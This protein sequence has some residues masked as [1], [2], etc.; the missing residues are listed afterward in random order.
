MMYG[1]SYPWKDQLEIC[2]SQVN[3]IVNNNDNFLTIFRPRSIAAS[4]LI[5]MAPPI[6]GS[7]EC[8]KNKT[9]EITTPSQYKGQ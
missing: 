3:Q 4:P 6:V 5:F 2:H 7:I 1:T 8:G 9:K